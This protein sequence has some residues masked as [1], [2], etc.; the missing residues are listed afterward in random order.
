MAL[1]R[2]GIR[3]RI[4]WTLAFVAA[5]IV[6]VNWTVLFLIQTAHRY[7]D[8]ELGRRLE[9]TAHTAALLIRPDQLDAILPQPGDSLRDDFESLIDLAG[10]EDT[11]RREWDVL[12]EGAGAGNVILIDRSYH[13]RLSRREALFA[14]SERVF[15][16]YAALARAFIGDLSHS[17]LYEVEGTYL[18]TGYAPLTRIDGEVAGVVAVEGGS[19]AF[20]PL[21]QIKAPILSASI[22]ASLFG[23]LIGLAYV[24][25]LGRLARV[26]ESMRHADLLAS[27]GQLAAGIAHEIRNP[28]AVLRGASSRLRKTEKL[29][30]NERTEL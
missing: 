12:A 11:I 9:G 25:T 22:L 16:D 24:R 2:K 19:E 21:D 5:L 23:L 26:E 6:L 18:K 30:G 13:V 17:Q 28:L 1:L 10:A 8:E 20:R 14:D 29:T 4:L 27:V 7:L 3:T 15:L